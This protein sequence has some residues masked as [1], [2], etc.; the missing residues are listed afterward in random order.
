MLIYDMW[1]P[2]RM[3][4]GTAPA[5]AW[6]WAQASEAVVGHSIED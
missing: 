4:L 3:R 1:A 5:L 6:K 2:V